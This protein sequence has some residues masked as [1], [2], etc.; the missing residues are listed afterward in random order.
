MILQNLAAK[1]SSY[2]LDL[3][4]TF[5]LFSWYFVFFIYYR[6]VVFLL[7]MSSSTRLEERQMAWWWSRRSIRRNFDAFCDLIVEHLNSPNS[8]KCYIYKV[9]ARILIFSV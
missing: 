9:L 7:T 1:V 4:L 3:E 8:G 2:Y 6:L 5:Q